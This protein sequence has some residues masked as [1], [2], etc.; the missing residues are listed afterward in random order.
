LIDELDSDDFKIRQKALAELRDLGD[1]AE[2]ALRK[3]LIG[4]NVSAELRQRIASLIE[5]SEK[6]HV[7]EVRAIAI[8]EHIGT[9]EACDLIGKLASGKPECFLTKEAKSASARVKDQAKCGQQ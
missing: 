3:R 7:R 2:V 1:G 8:L 5:E 6:R 9:E 4:A